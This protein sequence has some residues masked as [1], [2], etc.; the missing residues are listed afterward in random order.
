MERTKNT[1]NKPS[2]DLQINIPTRNFIR[3]HRNDDVRSLAFSAGKNPE[4][5]VPLALDQIKGWQT[6][7]YKLPSWAET[8]G[9]IY[10]PHLNMEQCSSEQTARYKQT[11]VAAGRSSDVDGVLVD[12][13]GGFGVDF[14]FL[15]QCFVKAVYVERDVR[16]CAVA[17][18]NFGI[19]GLSN[20]EV[21]NADGVEVLKA[22]SGDNPLLM[23]KDGVRL[24]LFIYLDPARRDVHGKKVYNIADCEPDVVSLASLLLSVADKVMIKLSPMFDWREAVRELPGVTDVHIVSVKN[25]CKELLVVMD[26]DKAEEKREKGVCVHCVNDDDDFSFVF[27]GERIA[28]FSECPDAVTVERT[29]SASSSFPSFLLVPNASVMK[30]GCFT[31]L[32]RQFGVSAISVN[33][34]LFLSSRPVADFP[35]RQFCVVA[36]SSMNKKELKRTLA[37]ITKANIAVR[38]FPMTVDALRKR[39]KIKEGGDV[40]IFAT[41]YSDGS[42]VL[43]IT[44]KNV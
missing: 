3:L 11:I 5:D 15:S 36:V 34:H 2:A 9:I 16:L 8:D 40:Y 41:T 29:P 38:N 10:P 28:S 31:E 43:I 27:G 19:L 12:L 17:R 14:S 25:E 24:P 44:K 13:T 39:L 6:A 22:L 33:S 35:G 4:V 20:V 30:A 37:G 18:H 42:H 1:E 23:S 21:V 26:G 32:T 7:R